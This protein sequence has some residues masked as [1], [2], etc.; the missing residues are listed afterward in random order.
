MHDTHVNASSGGFI[1]Q[2]SSLCLII[3]IIILRRVI[4]FRLAGKFQLHC[5]MAVE[6]HMKNIFDYLATYPLYV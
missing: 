3:M 5:S 2:A 1:I 6:E 4:I